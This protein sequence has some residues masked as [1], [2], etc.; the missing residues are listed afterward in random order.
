M[1][2]GAGNPVTELRRSSPLALAENTQ[3]AG[4]FRR[5]D[6]LAV[7]ACAGGE[8]QP[9]LHLGAL[10]VKHRCRRAQGVGAEQE[11]GRQLRGRGDFDERPSGA[12]RV[13]RLG[14]VGGVVLL[15]PPAG[16]RGVIVDRRRG[17]RQR[18]TDNT[19]VSV[20][21]NAKPLA[22]RTK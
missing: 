8:F 7:E 21:L 18:K 3:I 4:H 20:P 17:L 9:L 11:E 2:N 1:R 6:G 16:G 15:A 14:A 10:C 5:C 19:Q 12:G 13:A 22:G